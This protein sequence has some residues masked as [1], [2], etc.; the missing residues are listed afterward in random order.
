MVW[1]VKR[2]SDNDPLATNAN[3]A[4]PYIPKE[5]LCSIFPM[6]N[7]IDVKNPGPASSFST[8]PSSRG[9]TTRLSLSV[10]GRL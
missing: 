1:F 2:L 4:A 6:I 3:Q 7:R 8:G 10:A 5:F 9:E